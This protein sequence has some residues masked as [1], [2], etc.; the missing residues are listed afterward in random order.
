LRNR[1][2]LSLEWKNDGVMDDKSGD[3][4][5]RQTDRQKNIQRE[6]YTQRDRTDRHTDKPRNTQRDTDRH[7]LEHVSTSAISATRLSSSTCS[8][9]GRHRQ[10]CTW[11]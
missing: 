4:D 7:M 3:D 2:V 9:T 5:T 1:K 11:F 6:I 8:D 10:S